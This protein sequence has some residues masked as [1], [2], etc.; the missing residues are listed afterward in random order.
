MAS[1]ARIPVGTS[2][3]TPS[4]GAGCTP[5]SRLNPVC[6]ATDRL[7]HRRARH[8]NS[9][10]DIVD[11]TVK[12][13][14]CTPA[15]GYNKLLM[16]PQSRILILDTRRRTLTEAAD[17]R[18]NWQADS[19]LWPWVAALL[20]RLR[21]LPGPCG[22]GSAATSRGRPARCVRDRWARGLSARRRTRAKHRGTRFAN[23]IR[24]TFLQPHDRPARMTR[25]SQTIG[26]NR[27]A[28]MRRAAQSPPSTCF[29][30]GSH[31]VS[32][33]MY[34]F[35]VEFPPTDKVRVCP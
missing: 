1:F 29:S 23:E 26:R 32:F 31:Y 3:P 30:D 28:R 19:T 16:W 18:R 11:R 8:P 34:H 10:H 13:R 22:Q 4:F 9:P 14:P 12:V 17:L 2:A 21:V 15:R 7:A 27:I 6:V 24:R 35:G 33:W 20:Y 25:L 5:R